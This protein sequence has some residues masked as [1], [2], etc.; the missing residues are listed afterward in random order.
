LEPKRRETAAKPELRIADAVVH[1]NAT[2]RQDATRRVR[3]D[4]ADANNDVIGRPPPL[5]WRHLDVIGR[6]DISPPDTVM[7]G[8]L[9]P[10]NKTTAAWEF[11][12]AFARLAVALNRTAGRQTIQDRRRMVAAAFQVPPACPGL[13]PVTRSAGNSP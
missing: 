10:P 1:W 13:G 7:N 11:R 3:L 2:Y 4:R 9:R 6:L 8:D 5:L 12:T